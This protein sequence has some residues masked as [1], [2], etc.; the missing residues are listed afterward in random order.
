[1]PIQFRP[2]SAS[3][4][5][6]LLSKARYIGFIGGTGSGKTCAGAIKTIMK[7][8]DGFDGAVVAPDFPQLAKSTWPEFAKWLPWS[9]CTNAHLDHPYTSKKVLKFNV[10][11]KIVSVYYGGIE[12]PSAWTGLN[13]NWAWLDEMGRK[14][15]RQAFDVLAARIRIGPNPQ[16]W[17]TTTPNGVSHWLHDIFVKGIFNEKVLEAIRASG[18]TGPIVERFHGKTSDNREHLD[19]IHYLSLTGLYAGK[20]AQQELE[21]EFITMEGRVWEHFGERNITKEAD[22]IPGVP[23]EWWVDDGFTRG[24]PRVILFAQVIPPYVNV[25]DEYIAEYEVA[26]ESIHNALEKPSKKMP[27]PL[28]DVAYVD[29]SAA[30]LRSRL[31]RSDIDTVRATHSVEEGIK[32]AASWIC[33]GK[34]EAHLRI[35]P[36]CTFSIQEVQSYVINDRTGKPL[37][38]SDNVA[39]AIRYGLWFKDMAAIIEDGADYVS[40]VRD[41]RAAPE[42]VPAKSPSLLPKFPAGLLRW[43]TSHWYTRS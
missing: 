43:Y 9:R 4:R 30:E 10:R 13:I 22:Y 11:G 32:R 18:H 25:F 8:E 31:W 16:L 40:P 26:E 27:Y 3:Q 42:E 6:F 36:R 1:V 12:D 5:D 19:D 34:M 38:K 41:A 21:G 39:D 23:I 7:L 24:H 28:P 35:H 29:S 17:I 37:K 14:P 33:N 2:N 15:T 20:L